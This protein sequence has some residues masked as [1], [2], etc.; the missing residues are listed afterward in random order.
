G[1][2]TRDGQS[3][4]EWELRDETSGVDLKTL[5]VE[6]LVAGGRDWT[7]LYVQ[8][9]AVGSH[10]WTAAASRVRLRVRDKAGNPSEKEVTLGTGTGTSYAE[11]RGDVVMVNTTKVNLKY[12]IEEAGQ[13]GIKEVEIW[14]LRDNRWSAQPQLTKNQ[15][16]ET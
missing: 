14:V 16:T 12:K 10:N 1:S 15:E 11:P 6:Y 7:P 5:Q 3:A 2:T 9:G 8:A 13:S 4:I